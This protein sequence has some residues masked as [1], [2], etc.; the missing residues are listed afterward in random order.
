MQVVQKRLGAITVRVVRDEGF[1][2]AD[3]EQIIREF[4][5]KIGDEIEIELDYVED[6]E[7]TRAG[8]YIS[9][10]VYSDVTVDTKGEVELNLNLDLGPNLKAK[11]GVSSDGNTSLGIFFEKDY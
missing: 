6:I 8:K 7:R 5:K 9:D 1:E 11:G 10:N 3:A 2:T 4:R